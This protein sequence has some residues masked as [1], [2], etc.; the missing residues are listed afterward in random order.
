MSNLTWLILVCAVL[1]ACGCALRRANELFALSAQGG[2]LAV[3]RGRL[4]QAL[5]AELADIAEREQLDGA[6]LRVVSEGGAP[7]L[8]LAGTPH[9]AAA[10]AAR[11]VL[12]RY[13]LSQIRSG[14]LRAR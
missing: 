8:V 6:E 9:P 11:N 3:L 7:R 1:L 10:Q 12:G 4:P 2:R 5:F 14:R 13:N